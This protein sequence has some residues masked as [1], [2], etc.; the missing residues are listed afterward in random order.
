M[1]VGTSIGEQFASL[2]NAACAAADEGNARMAYE[3][4][5][6]LFYTQL[7]P[8][9]GW[10]RY[11]APGTYERR[12]CGLPRPTGEMDEVILKRRVAYLLIARQPARRR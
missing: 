11:C 9:A 5:Q 4:R 2:V 8:E 3:F 6:A 7:Q 1:P 10:S 12:W